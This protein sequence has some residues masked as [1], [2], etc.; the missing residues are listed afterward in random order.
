MSHPQ[1]SILIPAAG[2]SERLGQAKQLVE[3]RGRSLIQNAVT[4]AFSISPFEVLVV[5]GANAKA[6]KNAVHQ[7][8]VRWLH[9]PRWRTGMGSSIALGAT[10]INPESNGLMILLCDQ[11]RIQ[12]QDL[13]EL[14]VTWQSSPERIVCAEAEGRYI[15]PVIFPRACFNELLGLEGDQGARGLFKTHPELITPV[16]IKNAIFDL[17][18]QTQLD[19]LRKL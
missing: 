11:W 6:V 3:Y 13:R 9:N 7:P 17:D 1:L 18:T 8:S 19:E 5:T 16:P 10:L 15:P 4:S 2:A 14:A 12:P